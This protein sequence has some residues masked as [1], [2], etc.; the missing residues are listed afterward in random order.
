M[1]HFEAGKE[2]PVIR[3]VPGDVYTERESIMGEDVAAEL[4]AGELYLIAVLER[5]HGTGHVGLGLLRGDEDERQEQAQD[6]LMH[7]CHN[8]GNIKVWMF[9]LAK[10]QKLSYTRYALT[11]FFLGRF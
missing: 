9:N 3:M 1:S 6:D 5:H 10:I 8:V 2:Y 11:L 7:D 4:A